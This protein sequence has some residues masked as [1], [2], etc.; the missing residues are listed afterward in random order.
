MIK[1]VVI[2]AAGQGT[3][4]LHLTKNKPKH[5]IKVKKVAFLAYLLDNLLE[6]GYKE[7]ILVVGY[8]KEQVLDFLKE[9]NYKISTVDQFEVLGRKEYGT[10]SALKCVKDII[11]KENFLMVYGDNLY[12]VKDL[13]SFNIEDKYNYISGIYHQKPEKYGVLKIENSFLKEI[14]EKPRR[15]VGNLIN[16]GLYK[17]TP[18]IFD[19]VDKIQLSKRKEY[20]VTDA[21][22]LLAK[23]RKVKVKEIEDYWLDFGSPADIIKIYRFLEN[24]NF[25]N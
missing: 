13:Q 2:A 24:G 16:T 11:G 6:A 14:V 23:D 20:E 12:S 4:M 22:N 9:H 15:F 18:E 19:K 5:L 17:F 25:K 1:K 8:K 21:I 3:R 7:L 10:A